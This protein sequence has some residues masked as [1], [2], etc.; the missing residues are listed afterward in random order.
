MIRT[1]L[2]LATL[3]GVTLMLSACG[4]SG[5]ND[6]PAERARPEDHSMSHSPKPASDTAKATEATRAYMAANGA[7]HEAMDFQYTGNADRDFI[8]SMIPH[9]EG[10]V[11]T[12]KIALEHGRD[13]EVRALA[14]QVIEAQER[15]VDQMRAIERRLIGD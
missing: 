4:D 5:N 2:P 15:E 1:K 7:M 9:H 8:T 6:M 12:A 14:E 11:A 3:A 10:A 13:P